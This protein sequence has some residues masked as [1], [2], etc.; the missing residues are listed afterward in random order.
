MGNEQIKKRRA[1]L[2]GYRIAEDEQTKQKEAAAK[3]KS[4]FGF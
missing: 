1:E 2:L 3:G 4:A